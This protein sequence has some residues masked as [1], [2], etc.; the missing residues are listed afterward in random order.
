MAPITQEVLQTFGPFECSR[1]GAPTTEGVYWRGSVQ[2]RALGS[3]ESAIVP[4]C[5]VAC[6]ECLDDGF[7]GILMGDAFDSAGLPA[8]L[9]KAEAQAWRVRAFHAERA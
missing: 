7:L 4:G 2:T 3:S 9:G 6:R 1:C 8:A 5:F